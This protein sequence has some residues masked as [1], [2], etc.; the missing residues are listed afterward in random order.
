M[1]E[2]T[3]NPTSQERNKK[4]HSCTCSRCC[5]LEQS[6]TSLWNPLKHTW[7]I[8]PPTEIIYA[9]IENPQLFLLE[10]WSSRTVVQWN[11]WLDLYI[12]WLLFYNR[13]RINQNWFPSPHIV[14]SNEWIKSKTRLF[15]PPQQPLTEHN[16]YVTVSTKT[17]YVIYRLYFLLLLVSEF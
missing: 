15:D 5:L 9:C 16:T 3:Q 1:N 11:V 4:R 12:R 17:Q 7:L 13:W 8:A 2:C 6:R 14:L 10:Y